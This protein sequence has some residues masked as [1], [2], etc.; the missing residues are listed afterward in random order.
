MSALYKDITKIMLVEVLRHWS[1]VYS[2]A[3]ARTCRSDQLDQE[4]DAV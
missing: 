2:S 3:Y 4:I 1:A